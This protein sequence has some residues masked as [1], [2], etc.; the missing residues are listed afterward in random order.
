[1]VA[2]EACL[3]C[4]GQAFPCI[5]PPHSLPLREP[6]PEGTVPYLH[7]LQAVPLGPG[8]TAPRGKA[9]Q[10][11]GLWGAEARERWG[12]GLLSRV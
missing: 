6:G 10:T 12:P 5:L 11:E 4:P 1:M 9:L 8:M 3:R 7:A 2:R